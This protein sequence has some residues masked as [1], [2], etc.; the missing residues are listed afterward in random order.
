MTKL[1][2]I[3]HSA[4]RLDHAVGH[5]KLEHGEHPPRGVVPDRARLA[6]IFATGGFTHNPELRRNFLD[7]PV[8]GGCAATTN[9]GDIVAVASAV[10]AQLRNMNYAW[11]C[12]VPLEKAIAPDPGMIGMF[13]V[14]GDSM[15]FVNKYGRR[16]VNE[17][18]QYNELAQT[19]FQWDPSAAEYPNLVLAQVWDQRSQDHSASTEYGRLIVPPGTD[20]SHVIKGETLEELTRRIDERVARDFHRGERAVQLLFNGPVKEE[21]GRT[22]PTLWPLSDTGPYYAALVTGGTLDTKGGPKATPDGQIV[23]DLDQP[24]PGLYGVGNCVASASAQAYWAGGATLGPIVAFAYRAAH[25]AHAEPVKEVVQ[26][27]R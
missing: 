6:V 24:I 9:E 5:L 3:D 8:Y 4:D 1:V 13:S 26:A 14:A 18:L 21:P 22:N 27:A 16:V 7:V 12:P 10:G 2:G 15:V 11:M 17:K 25:A 19:F 23:D 20:D